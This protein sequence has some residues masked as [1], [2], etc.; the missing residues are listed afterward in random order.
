[1]YQYDHQM[2]NGEDM[3]PDR[4]EDDDEDAMHHGNS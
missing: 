4:R 2:M 3:S 1:M